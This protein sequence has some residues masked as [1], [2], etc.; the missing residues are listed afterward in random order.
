MAINLLNRDSTA[1]GTTGERLLYHLS[2]DLS[3][4]KICHDGAKRK[5]FLDVLASPLADAD[6]ILY[7]QN[8]LRDFL[9]Y[10][11]LLAKMIALAEE[12]ESIRAKWNEYRRSKYRGMSDQALKTATVLAQNQCSVSAMTLRALLFFIRDLSTLLDEYDSESEFLTELLSE[13]KALIQN[14]AFS[15]LITVCGELEYRPD[16]NPVD[17]RVT[18]DEFGDINSAELIDHKYILV[19]DPELKQK[20]SWLKKQMPERYPCER[21]YL[22]RADAETLFPSPFY[23]LANAI[24]DIVKQIFDR[25]AG[26]KEELQFYEVAAE[27]CS[28]LSEKGANYIFPNFTQ[29]GTTSIEK[30]Y[31]LQLLVTSESISDIVPH[32]LISTD[33][34]ERIVVYG[35]N[36]SG[37]T[38]FL[39]SITTMQ[40]LAQAG[41]PI[42]S[43]SA[44]LRIYSAI[45]TQFAE[46]EKE[47][48]E[49]NDAGRFEQEVREI[50]ALLNIAPPHSFVIL[51]ETFQTTAY[52]EGAEGIY[53]ILRYLSSE[54]ISYIIA[55]HMHQLLEMLGD[56]VVSLHVNSEHEL[57]RE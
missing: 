8:I 19:T 36:G 52:D 56:E 34:T 20:R 41:L 12:F 31:D 46:S 43:E 24:D 55:T 7:R 54:G 6:S 25:Y 17:L 4:S 45:I 48:E 23:E 15:R 32:S 22:T 1:V 30:L 13:S 42:P 29:D 3:L 9:A 39:R 50:A 21:V 40:L 44:Q 53:H 51:N 16:M 37:K 5:Y 18:L 35:D 49:G 14:E 33:N 38:S 2:L 10:P 11:E 27:Y 26:I 47:F 57:E 28:F